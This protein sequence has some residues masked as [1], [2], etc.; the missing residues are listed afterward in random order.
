MGGPLL[1]ARWRIVVIVHTDTLPLLP[2]TLASVRAQSLGRDISLLAGDADPVRAALVDLELPVAYDLPA[3]IPGGGFWSTVACSYRF[4]GEPVLFLQAGCLVPQHW[5]ARLVAAGQRN[6]AAGIVAPVSVRHPLTSLFSSTTHAPGLAVDDIDQWLNEYSDG[7]AFPLPALPHGCLLFQGGYWQERPEDC[8][9]DEHLFERLAND[10]IEVL[11]D[12]QVYIDDAALAC[13]GDIQA[14]PLA[15]RD[16]YSMRSPL[17]A[18]RHPLTELSARAERPPQV[19]DCR[20]VQLHVG[21]SWGGG[22]GQWMS[23]FIAADCH[24]NHLVLR[25]I[26][27]RTGFGQTIALYGDA[28]MDSPIRSWT[29]SQPILSVRQ[30]C[31]EYRAIIAELVESYSVESIVVSSVI[32]HTLD[33]LHTSLPTTVVLHDF[34]PFCPALYATFDT[35]CTGCT[36]ERLAACGRDNPQ[37]HYFKFESSA[38]WLGVRKFFLASLVQEHIT[39]AAPS[40]SVVER[41]RVLAPE[42]GGK[43]ISVVAHGLAG[44]LIASLAPGAEFA[45][46]AGPLRLVVLGRLTAEKGGE[47]LAAIVDEVVGFAELHL[48][49]TGES[50]ARFEK[51]VNVPVVRSYDSAELGALLRDIRPHLALLLSVVPETFSYTLS[52]LRAAAVPVL[53]TNVGAFVERIDEG[54]TGWLVQ[55]DAQSVLERLRALQADRAALARV[56]ATLAGAAARTARAMCDDYAVLSPAREG[57]PLSRYWLP[58]RS[59][60][61]PYAVAAAQDEALIV[62]RHVSYR[63]VLVAFLRYSAGK[64][65]VSARLPGWLRPLVIR[66]LRFLARRLAA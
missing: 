33:I 22:V 10:R 57:I 1:S 13:A 43:P 20:P 36:A 44:D 28:G 55:P 31:P 40:A 16:A 48:L 3:T 64:A 2:N 25:S 29:L 56:R 37:H 61:N 18:L 58:R 6:P 60:T 8:A 62:G 14:L 12:T 17:A 30:N 63:R 52:E 45:E 38:H 42:L 49:G 4:S 19:R 24:N 50:G 27:D 11:A 59:H 39:L 41:Y 21:H 47:I 46:D 32:G 35:P 15:V 7:R 54:E 9:G 53:A 51:T 34:F 66:P 23:D 5:D 26:G 65:E